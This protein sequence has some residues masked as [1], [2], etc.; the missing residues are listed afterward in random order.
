MAGIARANIDYASTHSAGET[1]TAPAQ[2]IYVGS[3]G[4]NVYVNGQ[5]AI[6]DQDV[7]LC[8]EKVKEFSSNVFINGKGVHRLGDLLDSHEGT[9][10]PSVCVS[11]S[12]NVFAN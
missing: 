5:V 6:V 11:A 2:T 3:G 8:G 12:S 4:Q 10:S 7:T 9:F 1:H